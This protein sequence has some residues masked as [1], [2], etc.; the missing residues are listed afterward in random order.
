M[1]QISEMT[2]A[3]KEQYWKQLVQEFQQKAQELGQTIPPQMAAAVN[4]A[5]NGT[6]QQSTLTADDV[7]RANDAF[8]QQ[9]GPGENQYAGTSRHSAPSTPGRGSSRSTYERI[10]Q[11]IPIQ[12]FAYGTPGADWSEW[13]KRFEVAVQ[14]ATNAQGKDRLE[15]LC[16]VWIALKLTDEGLP[17][18]NQCPSKDTSWPALRGE[19]EK[20]FEDTQVKRSWIRSMGAY[21]K[22]ADMSL[23]VY[24]A[25]VMGMVSRYSPATLNDAAAYASELYNR[26]V[27]GLEVDWREYIEES[28]PFG[29]E[30]IDN[31]Y[32]QALKYEEK[33]KKK[34]V[35]FSGAA[36]TDG[37]KNAMECIR[38]DLQELK[39]TVEAAE[40]ARKESRER[41]QA[42][43][44]AQKGDSKGYEGPKKDTKDSPHAKKHTSPHKSRSSSGRSFSSGRSRSSGKG[45]SSEKFRAIKTEDEDSD[46]ETRKA[47]A[48]AVSTA[49]TEGL[50][51]MSLKSK[52][53]SKKHSKS[54]KA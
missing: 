22:P 51:G 35:D 16:L 45:S 21:K 18:Y 47:I 20:A 36:M 49:V 52:S 2:Q 6:V 53:S 54:K 25:K 8:L 43:K 40:R 26:F 17:I 27:G 34:A 50:K 46:A 5:G 13:S 11:D 7:R 12:K 44:K 19:L 14:A 23:P 48:K 4:G 32:N 28:I 10:T 3:Q 30:T 29:K 33:L 9:T 38:L 31:A 24:K 41:W 37:E 15:E 1:S 42:R 39:T